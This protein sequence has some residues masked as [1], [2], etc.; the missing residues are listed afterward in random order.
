[1]LKISNQSFQ[2]FEKNC[3]RQFCKNSLKDLKQDS[4]AVNPENSNDLDELITMSEQLESEGLASQSL[5]YRYF[6]NFHLFRQTFIDSPSL[7]LELKKTLKRLPDEHTRSK[8]LDT[9]INKALEENK[10]K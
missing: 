6:M 1:M 2:A 3:R 9:M 7:H 10:S 4:F 5:Q 8:Y